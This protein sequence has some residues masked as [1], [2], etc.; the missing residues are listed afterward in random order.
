MQTER[1]VMG[2]VGICRGTGWYHETSPSGPRKYAAWGKLP[3]VRIS[4]TGA[5]AGLLLVTEHGTD[6]HVRLEPT[7]GA[8]PQIGAQSRNKSL[9]LRWDSLDVLSRSSAP[10]VDL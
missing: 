4:P 9:T 6:L 2:G 5:G 10:A 3:L 1:A 8:D 7:L